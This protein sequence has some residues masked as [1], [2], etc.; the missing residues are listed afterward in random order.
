MLSKKAMLRI[1]NVY[2]IP[3]PKQQQKR[4]GEN[5]L[6]HTFFVATNITKLK[7]ILFLNWR[8]KKFG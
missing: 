1:R 6:S 8:R 5:V 2:T 4:R 7:H 3:D